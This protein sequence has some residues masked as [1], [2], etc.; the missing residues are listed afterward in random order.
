LLE[1][2]STKQRL[3]LNYYPPGNRYATAYTVGEGLD[4]LGFKVEDARAWFKKLLAAGAT[5]AVEPYEEGPGEV[6]SY[7]RDPDGNWIEVY[8]SP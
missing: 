2:P 4:H 6:V 3:E 7:L 1:D 5:P 8:Q